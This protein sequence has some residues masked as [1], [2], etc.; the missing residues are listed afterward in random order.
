MKRETTER[1]TSRDDGN[2][3]NP[4]LVALGL[5]AGW[6]MSRVFARTVRGILHGSQGSLDVPAEKPAGGAMEQAVER[7]NQSNQQLPPPKKGQ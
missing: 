7:R 1:T 3:R 5:S 6:E 4:Y 2:R